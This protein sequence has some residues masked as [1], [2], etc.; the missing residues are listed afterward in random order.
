M[1]PNGEI[2]FG[3]KIAKNKDLGIYLRNTSTKFGQSNLRNKNLAKRDVLHVIP[4][5]LY[6]LHV[7]WCH[8]VLKFW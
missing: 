2:L 4:L 3:G 5:M 7:Q 1:G 6:L 8:T